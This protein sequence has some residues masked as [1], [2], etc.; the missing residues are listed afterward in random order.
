MAGGRIR[1]LGLAA[2]SGL[3]LAGCLAAPAAA[4]PA[5]NAA[6]A[7]FGLKGLFPGY[8]PQVH[9]YVVRCENRGVAVHSH[10]VPPWRV[11][12]GDHPFRSGDHD[13]FVPL[14]TGREFTVTIQQTGSQQFYR[15]YV[16]CLPSNFPTYTFTKSGPVSPRFFTADDAFAPVRQRYAMLFDNNGVPVWWYHLSVWGP[17][18]LSDGRILWFHSN[19]QDSRFEVRRLDGRIV[20]RLGA[21]AGMPLDGHDLQL[22]PGGGYLIGGHSPQ[23]HV[24]LSPYGGP[25]DATVLNTELQEVS[26]QGKLLWDWRSQDHIARAETGRWWPYVISHPAPYGYDVPHWNSIEP[27]GNAVIA[28][29]RQLD[30]VYKI[31]Q[32]TG[33][34][35]WKL[36]G[37]TTP[38]S[39]TVV[40]DP[41]SYPLGGQHDARVLP[42]GT[43]S[44]FDNRTVLPDQTPRMARY[45][46]DQAAQTATL[47]QS[48][49]DPDVPLSY[50]CGSARQLPNRDWLI[51]WGRGAAG[52]QAGGSI[53]GYAPDGERTFRLAFQSTY[54]YRALPVPSGSVTVKQLRENMD[55]MCASG[56]P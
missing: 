7:G 44:I 1:Q 33:N 50:C 53:G 41:H 20:R 28:S 17:R 45:R 6:L 4:D 29:F 5:P 16:R 13:V 22:L 25:S 14:R 38:R 31:N 12:V 3:A 35:V 55:A 2:I 23:D 21:A 32:A 9:D 18:V 46:I 24:D 52:A 49:S 19:G 15:Y 47:V 43:V 27:H 37:T 40:D 26:P 10:A 36:G 39:L 56:C 48:I 54:S 8:D 34:T 42:D 30:A 51:D 11:A